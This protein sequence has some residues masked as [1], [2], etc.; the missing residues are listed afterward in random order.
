VID[1][2]SRIQ[3][4]V[5]DEA[6]HQWQVRLRTCVGAIGGHFEHLLNVLLLHCWF[7][8]YIIALHDISLKMFDAIITTF[9]SRAMFVMDI[10]TTWFKKPDPC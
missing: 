8:A 2:W 10:Y 1:S 5:I 7:I 4:T 6:I 9:K 3:K